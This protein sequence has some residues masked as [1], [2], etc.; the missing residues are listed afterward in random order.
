MSGQCPNCDSSDLVTATYPPKILT[1]CR[2]CGFIVGIRPIPGTE[3]PASPYR[4][5][6]RDAWPRVK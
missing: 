2:T 3:Q 6:R 5:P 4:P 1:Q